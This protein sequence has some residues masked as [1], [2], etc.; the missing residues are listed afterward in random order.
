MT[1]SP[2][3]PSWAKFTVYAYLLRTTVHTNARAGLDTNAN[4]DAIN[5]G[6]GIPTGEPGA[7]SADQVE[8]LLTVWPHDRVLEA[9]AIEVY[10]LHVVGQLS[11]T[12]MTEWLSDLPRR[13]AF[14]VGEGVVKSTKMQILAL[15]RLGLLTRAEID[16]D[17]L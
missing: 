6:M 3:R 4:V 17:H 8:Y 13:D 10:A 12:Q 7:I 15:A 14:K 11:R 2:R 16:L 1:D 9:T 5:T